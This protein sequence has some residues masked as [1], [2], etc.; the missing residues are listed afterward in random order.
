MVLFVFL[1]AV[2]THTGYLEYWNLQLTAYWW[3]SRFLHLRWR[4]GCCVDLVLLPHHRFQPGYRSLRCWQIDLRDLFCHHPALRR[5]F[6]VS[7]ASDACGIRGGIM[8]HRTHLSH[9][10][11]SL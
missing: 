5:F 6:V 8:Q 1:S 11:I 3:R 9:Q 7:E 10:L 2:L 4:E